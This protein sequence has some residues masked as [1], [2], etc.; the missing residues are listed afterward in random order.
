MSKASKKT[1]DAEKIW[2]IVAPG[3]W[4]EARTRASTLRRPGLFLDRDGVIVHDKGFLAA[5]GDV[6]LLPGAAELIAQANRCAIPVAVVTNQSGIARNLFSWSDFAGVEREIARRLALAG[7]RVDAVAACPFHPEFTANYGSVE[8]H[9]RKP[10]P[11]LVLATARLMN[12]DIAMSWLVG[13]RLRD[14]EAARKAGLAGAIH[15]VG[16]AAGQSRTGENT[17]SSDGFPVCQA[18]TPAESLQIL[19]DVGLLSDRA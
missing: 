6:E 5:P 1:V 3:I 18:A 12:I 9:W 17:R 10:N 16:D 15:L 2:P 4:L 7:A 11:G 14:I 19:N 13:D 8:S